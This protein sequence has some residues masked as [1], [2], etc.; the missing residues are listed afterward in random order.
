[1]DPEYRFFYLN[2]WKTEICEELFSGLLSNPINPEIEFCA[3][4]IDPEDRRESC[5]GDSGGPLICIVEVLL[6]NIL[7]YAYLY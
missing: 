7:I 5:I 4:S 3:G 2:T 1:M 6:Y